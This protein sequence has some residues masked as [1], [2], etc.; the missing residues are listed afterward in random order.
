MAVSSID[1]RRRSHT[2]WTARRVT[3]MGLGRHGGGVGAA[4]Y[5]ATAG[6]QLTISELAAADELAE[7]L[8]ALGGLPIHALHFGGHDESDFVGADCVVVNPAVRPD[9]PCPK[10]ARAQGA[11]VTSEIEL[12]LK[13]CPAHVIGVTGSNGK[14]TTATMLAAIL[15]AVGRPAWLGG[16]IGASL[17]DR[18]ESMSADDWVV[19]ELSS[20]Q[21]AHLSDAARPVE[22]AVVTNCTPNHLDWHASFADYAA[23]KRR[24]LRDRGTLAILNPHDGVSSAWKRQ[25]AAE[26]RPCWPLE[27]VRELAI[28]GI[29]NLQNAALAAAAAEAAGVSE[30]IIR[31][32]LRSFRGLAH[33]LQFVGSVAARR[34]Y[35]DSKATSP[36]ASI[37]ALDALDGPLWLVA[38]GVSKNAPLDQWAAHVVN[39]ACGAAVFGAAGGALAE[40]LRTKR[41]DYNLLQCESLAEAV[42]GCW[43]QSQAGDAILLSPACA[44][45]DQFRDFQERGDAFCKWVS[46]L[47]ARRESPARD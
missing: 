45:F 39:R 6:A 27:A 34:F 37:A 33:R 8:A 38:G 3:L 41:A 29:H 47:A 44:S 2:D 31:T 9:H 4:R 22:I 12:F 11:E 26:V 32:A 18:L 15:S 24:L 40:S 7:S 17:L 20:F 36:A 43:R 1:A 16:N 13:H 35:D 5:L 25:V 42:E 10:L 21:L 23:A 19:L 28:D 30:S 14:S 46:A